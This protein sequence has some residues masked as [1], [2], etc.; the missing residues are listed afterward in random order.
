MKRRFFIWRTLTNEFGNASYAVD[1]DLVTVVTPYGTKATQLGG[2][3]PQSIARL[4]MRELHGNSLN[5]KE[6]TNE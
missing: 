5:K 4:L 2:S 6:L 3:S 1:N